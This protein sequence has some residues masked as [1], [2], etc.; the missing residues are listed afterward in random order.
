MVGSVVFGYWLIKHA[1]AIQRLTRGVGDTVFLAADGKPWFRL[2]EHRYDVPLAE[3]SPHLRHA[4]IAVE[5]K[6]FYRH[7]GIDPLAF[8]R[9]LLRNARELR[10]AEGGSTI[11]QQLARTL[12]LNNRRNVGRKAQEAV[13]ALMLE[14][15]LTKEQILELYLNR[16]DADRRRP[17][18]RGDVA[19]AVLQE[20]PRPERRERPP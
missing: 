13:L 17:R 18:R 16:V 1:V 4:V 20:P 14:Q 6:R 10:V 12:F 3:I 11:T 15:A 9:A 7:P 8:G 5:D 19:R 2:D